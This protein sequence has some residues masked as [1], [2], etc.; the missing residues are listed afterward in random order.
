MTVRRL[1]VQNITYF[2]DKTLN[3]DDQPQLPYFMICTLPMNLGVW[4]AGKELQNRCFL[5]LHNQNLESFAIFCTCLIQP[6]LNCNFSLLSQS[7]SICSM[8]TPHIVC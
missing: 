5:Y 2:N 1:E 4:G 6:I 3:I 8:M 7:H